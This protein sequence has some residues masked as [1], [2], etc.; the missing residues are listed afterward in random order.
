MKQFVEE[1]LNLGAQIVGMFKK[2]INN[3][4]KQTIETLLTN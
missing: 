3:I 4:L 1:Q 2:R